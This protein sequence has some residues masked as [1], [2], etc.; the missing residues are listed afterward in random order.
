MRVILS[1]LKNCYCDPIKK[2]LRY[3]RL[4]PVVVLTDVPLKPCNPTALVAEHTATVVATAV[5][6]FELF[7]TLAWAMLVA[8]S[9][10]DVAIMV[11]DDDAATATCPVTRYMPVMGINS[12]LEETEN[13]YF[14]V[15][16]PPSVTVVN[17]ETP[18]GVA[19]E[20][21]MSAAGA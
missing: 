21:K 9:V 13:P 4:A 18:R 20:L 14:S 3:V 19:T 10:T 12:V 7:V 6:V 17:V 8:L 11:D 5:T 15:V 16:V 1:L 2:A